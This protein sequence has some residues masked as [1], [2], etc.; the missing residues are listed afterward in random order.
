MIRFGPSGIPLSCK[1]RTLKDGIEDIHTLGLN[2]MEVQFVRVN[3]FERFASE[4]E[5]GFIPTDVEGELIVDV[6]R[7]DAGKKKPVSLGVLNQKIISGDILKILL[8]RSSIRM[9]LSYGQGYL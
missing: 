9:D 4:E 1:G 3:V 8:Q 6:L 7:K 5:E 2:A